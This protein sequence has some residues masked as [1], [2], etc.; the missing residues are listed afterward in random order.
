MSAAAATAFQ[1]SLCISSQ[2]PSFS[3][4]NSQEPNTHLPSK[5]KSLLHKHPLYSSAHHNLSLQIKEKILCL[6][7]MGIDSGK[8]LSLNPSLHTTSLDSLN[9]IISFLQSKGIHQ[10]DFPRIFGMCPQ[11]LTSNIKAELGPVFS[12]LSQDLNVPENNYRKVINKCPRLLTSSVRDQ[13]KPALFYLQRLGFR[14]LEALA[15]QDP[16]LLV[17]S[18]EHTLIPKLKFLESIGFSTSAA[19]S[20]VLRCP[21]LFT[22]SIENN[23]KPKFE[24]FKEEMNGDLEEL[25]AFPQFFAFS[26][27]KRIKPRHIEAIKSGVKLPLANMLKSTDDEFKEL[28]RNNGANS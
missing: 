4:T 6:E 16:V 25:K 15:Y 17:S 1:S 2:K 24:Y 21:G 12:F 19:K 11:I 28:L 10:K 22:F 23:Y 7:I 13:L 3:P 14:D 8:A 20:M 26:L 18:V 9:S 5:P 27:E